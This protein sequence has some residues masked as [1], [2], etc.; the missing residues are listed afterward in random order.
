M[1][2]GWR[3][4]SWERLAVVLLFFVSLATRLPAPWGAEVI[5]DERKP[6]TPG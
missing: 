4:M 5:G 6:S 1:K 3:P 2:V